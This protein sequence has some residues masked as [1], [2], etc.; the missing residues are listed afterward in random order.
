MK[1][2]KRMCGECG[3]RPSG[4]FTGW[5]TNRGYRKV[6]KTDPN[7]VVCLQ[8]WRAYCNRERIKTDKKCP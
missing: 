5:K 8:C 2:K 6:W 1:K 7:H 3:K 4:Y